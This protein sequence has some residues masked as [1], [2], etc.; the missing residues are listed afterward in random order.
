MKGKKGA[1]YEGGHRVACFARWP[2]TFKAGTT[3]DN[4]TMHADWL[5]TLSELCD[6]K[7]PKNLNWD[8]RSIASLLEG[9]DRNWKDRSIFVSKQADEL[10]IWKPGGNQNAKY[11]HFAVLSENWRYVDG[12]LYDIQADPSQTKN[13]A[14]QHPEVTQTLYADYER[15]FNDVTEEGRPYNRFLLG[16]RDENPTRFTVRDWHPTEGGVI[17]KMELVEDDALFVNGFWAVDVQRSGR[18]EIRIARYPEDAEAPAE[19]NQARIQIGNIEK[20]AELNS[21][22]IAATFQVDLKK[23]PAL[24]KTWMRDAQTGQERGA[25][26]IKVTKL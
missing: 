18:Y 3:V 23:G 20:T 21:K 1:V 6:L 17:W 5:P 16:T 8:G 4:L 15:W 7:A 10:K 26:H 22:D 24:L 13:V 25:Y 9:K 14:N 12:E 2:Q 11:P 19:A